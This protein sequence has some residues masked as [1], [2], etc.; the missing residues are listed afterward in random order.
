M[1]NNTIIMNNSK[2]ISAK[3]LDDIKNLCLAKKHRYFPIE[4][5]YKHYNSQR[6][7]MVSLKCN[8]HFDVNGNNY[9]FNQR[10]EDLRKLKL[11]RKCPGCLSEIQ[12]SNRQLSIT[13]LREKIKYSKN[14]KIKENFHVIDFVRDSNG[15][16]L[17]DNFGNNLIRLKCNAL[18]HD[19]PFIQS[20]VNVGEQNA[21]P[22]CM[23]HVGFKKNAEDY[24]FEINEI[25]K[26]YKLEEQIKYN[27]KIDRDSS[28][29]IKYNFIC[30]NCNN[31]FWIYKHHINSAKCPDCNLKESSGENY[32]KNHL[33]F[34]KIPFEEQKKYSDLGNKSPFSYDFFLPKYNLCVEF[35]GEQHFKPLKIFGGKKKFFSQIRNDIK[36]NI[37][38]F[39]NKIN[40]LRIPYFEFNNIEN[41]INQAIHKI[42]NEDL[43]L[44]RKAPVFY[45]VSYIPFIANKRRKKINRITSK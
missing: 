16:I 5:Y 31:P 9:V 45:K 26:M 12:K 40:L 6:V 30:L 24:V 29:K 13:D 4:V 18:G 22:E 7:K 27:E 39:R 19:H 32:I 3:N 43:I 17:Q 11:S 10:I 8:K 25:V 38:C 37:Y 42:S 15:K 21:C 41:L 28:G 35:D 33:L 44:K 14:L 34:S 20:S 23:K 36:K 1:R 2:S